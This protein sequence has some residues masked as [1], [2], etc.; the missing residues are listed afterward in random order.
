MSWKPWMVVLD[1]KLGVCL[2]REYAR[3]LGTQVT[4]PEGYCGEVLLGPRGSK[5]CVE[6]TQV[7]LCGYSEYDWEEVKKMLDHISAAVGRQ[8]WSY[9]TRNTTA[10]KVLPRLKEFR[11]TMGHPN[12]SR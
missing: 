9:P 1:E 10:P 12:R 6:N 5:W 11:G 8:V 7:M 2:L 3:Q 4:W